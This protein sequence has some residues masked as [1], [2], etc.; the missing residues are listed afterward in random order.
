MIPKLIELLKN[1]LTELVYN[2]KDSLYTVINTDSVISI[3]NYL[4]TT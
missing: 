3:T 1:M 2:K 4:I